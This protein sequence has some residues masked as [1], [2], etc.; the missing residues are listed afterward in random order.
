MSKLTL[1]I[2]FYY[3]K[4]KG[5][6]KKSG[7]AYPT[8]NH[9]Y[10]YKYGKPH[11]TKWAIMYQE[12][13]RDWAKLWAEEHSWVMTKKQKIRVK[14]WAYFP[15]KIKRDMHNAY[16]IL[17]DGLEGVIFEDDQYVLVQSM[18]FDYSKDN[19]RFELEFEVVS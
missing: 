18:D 3:E 2:Q 15:N 4:G 5:K 11:L 16:K 9:C 10:Y 1:P 12:S 14:I 7:L 8:W 17:I 19:P 13:L 6:A